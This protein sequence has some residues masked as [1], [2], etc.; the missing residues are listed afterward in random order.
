MIKKV[1]I[2]G[3]AGFIGSNL[4]DFLLEETDWHID[5]IDNLSTGSKA[6]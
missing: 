2:T 4:L 5:G 3:V 1:L 6:N